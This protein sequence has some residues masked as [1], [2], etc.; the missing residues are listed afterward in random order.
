[1]RDLLTS[2]PLRLAL[3]ATAAMLALGLWLVAEIAD[4]SNAALSHRTLA[5]IEADT[6][7]LVATHARDGIAATAERIAEIAA[8]TPTG[9]YRLERADAAATGNLAA[10]PLGAGTG[11]SQTFNYKTAAPEPAVRLAVGLATEL[12]NAA[13]LV[14]ARDI[15][16]QRALAIRIRW[17]GWIGV[18][19]LT[20]SG[21]VLGLLAR[22][23]LLARIGTI[24]STSRAIMSGDLSKRIDRD[25]SADELDRLAGNLNDMLARI[26]SLMAALREVS[27]NIAH[28]LRTPLNRLRNTAEDALRQ[29]RDSAAAR[30]G[31]EKVIEQADELIKT[32]NA[33]LLIARLEPGDAVTPTEAVDLAALAA[34]VGELYEPVAE[35][36]GLTLRL[37]IPATP[38]HIAAHRQLLG[39]AVANLVDNAIKYSAG[40][41]G[42]TADRTVVVSIHAEEETVRLTVADHGPG[43]A[44]EDRERALKRFVRLEKSRSLPGTGLGLS[45]VAAV[46]RM[47]H[48][49]LELADNAPGLKVTLSF[50]R[51]P[52]P[53]KA[54][55]P[56]EQSTC[57]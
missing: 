42:L 35:E 53:P 31:L 56:S 10:W 46:A 38:L 34:D 12:G 57:V 43:I 16:D 7:M 19:G 4:Q 17:L 3:L 36:A 45:L 33:L 9:L 1:M 15:E 44:P 52:T 41:T 32:F 51:I 14:V 18:I 37:D 39:Q 48:A 2:T 5:A 25:G 30:A 55:I 20:V 22:R 54:S 23:A 8:R 21:L 47:H 26:E 24:T 29:S 27:D 28:D 40:T 13:R 6:A 11:R 49:T 50:P